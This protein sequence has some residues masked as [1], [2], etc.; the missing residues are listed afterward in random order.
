M[1][2]RADAVV[3]FGVTGDLAFKK[4]FPALYQLEHHSRLTG[5]VIGVARS[6]WEDRQL[7]EAARKSLGD[8]GTEVNTALFDQMASRMAMVSGSYA[9]RGLYKRLARQLEGAEHPLFYLAVPP[10]VFGNVVSGLASVGLA[11]RGR[12]VVE[13][14]FGH[15]RSSARDLDQLLLAAFAP[16]S[17]YRIDHYRGKESIEELL[18]MRFTNA[19]FEPLWNRDHITRIEITMA[20]RFGTQGRAG[21]YDTAGAIRDVL[22]NHMLQVA[23]LLAMEPPATPDGIEDELLKVLR[24]MRPLSPHTTVRGQYA[25]YPDEP[26]VGQ[27]ST[28]E[29]FVASRL[30]IASPRWEGVPFLLRA[31]K[32]LTANATDVVVELRRP[33]GTPLAGESTRDTHP[34]PHVVRLRLGR[35]QG[36][37]RPLPAVPP[38]ADV[39]NR[40]MD[41]MAGSAFA[42]GSKGREAYE[43]LI[44]DVI[45]GRRHRFVSAEAIDQQWRIVLPLID[46]PDQPLPYERGSWGPDEADLLAGGWHALHPRQHDAE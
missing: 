19:F 30:S 28:T 4:L 14:P 44:D 41:L 7:T 6:P 42:L 45:A 1:D 10:T 21:F 20:E 24:Q 3:V 12:V 23:A 18:A 15:D 38:G 36:G 22:Q 39:V 5:P 31:G 11:E 9:D 35:D 34:D 40:S 16:R 43:R 25:G 27:G 2:T 26:G 33:P 46:I 13:K 17:V 8:A 37:A 32:H 29:T